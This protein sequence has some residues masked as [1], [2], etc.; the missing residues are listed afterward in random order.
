MFEAHLIHQTLDDLPPAPYCASVIYIW[1]YS[2][3]IGVVGI[4]TMK[5]KVNEWKIF[6]KKK[7]HEL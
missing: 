3:L 1:I 6:I 2:S 7:I 4:L 5:K